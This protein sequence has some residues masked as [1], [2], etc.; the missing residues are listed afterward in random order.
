MQAILSLKCIYDTARQSWAIDLTLDGGAGTHRFPISPDQVEV[1]LEAFDD[2]S[3][4]EFDPASQ[5]VLFSYEYLDI[6][7]D[8]DEAEGGEEADE[9]DTDEQGERE[10]GPRQ[11]GKGASA[12]KKL[13]PA[14]KRKS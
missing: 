3:S 4:A 9:E 5:E 6:E 12:A 2:C 13:A 11:G 8:E 10:S 1:F 7:D 14:G